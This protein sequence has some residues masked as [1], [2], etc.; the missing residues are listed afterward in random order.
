MFPNIV[1]QKSVLSKLKFFVELQQ[2]TDIIPPILLTGARGCG[3]NSIAKQL[4]RNILSNGETRPAIEVNCCSLKK[5][6]DFFEQVVNPYILNKNATIILDEFHAVKGTEL[7]EMFLSILNPNDDYLNKYIYNGSEYS[8]DFRKIAF[9]FLTSEPD[10]LPETLL[11]RL[12]VIQLEELNLQDL[13]R[14]IQRNLR[15]IRADHKLLEEVAS[16]ARDNGRESQKL[17]QNIYRF[18]NKQKRKEFTYKDWIYI[19]NHLGIRKMGINNIEYKILKYLKHNGNSSLTKLSSALQLTT[20]AT[21]RHFETFLL[22]KGLIEIGA[23]KGRSLSALG[24][25]YLDEEIEE[26][27]VN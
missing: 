3:K 23:P 13:A 5:E 12:E 11:S 9:V 19:K 27:K 4:C 15:D 14:I 1:G 17:G 10:A 8:F 21:R 24:H 18:L 25:K 26:L 6:S 16:M 22:S 20:G 2:N 7:T